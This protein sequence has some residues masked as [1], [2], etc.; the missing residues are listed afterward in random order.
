MQAS[1]RLLKTTVFI[2]NIHCAT[3]TELIATTL[4]TL[5]PRPVS[6]TAS[7]LSNRVEIYH[8]VLLKPSKIVHALHLVG[9]DIESCLSGP[10]D[11]ESRQVL[12]QKPVYFLEEFCGGILSGLQSK[13]RKRHEEI[14]GRCIS[15]KPGSS[16]SVSGSFDAAALARPGTFKSYLSGDAHDSGA[17]SGSATPALEKRDIVDLRSI[18]VGTD[19]SSSC[20]KWVATFSIQGMTCSACVNTIR[21]NLKKFPYIEKAEISA[22]S[23]SG[24]IVFSGKDNGAIIAESIEDSGYDVEIIEVVPYNAGEFQTSER[25]ITL[26]VQGIHCPNCPPRLM[27]AMETFKPAQLTVVKPMISLNDPTIVIKYTPQPDINARKVIS[28]LSAV[29]TA[30]TVKVKP[31]QSIEDRSAS[32]HKAEVRRIRRRLAISIICAIPGFII[33]IVFMSLLPKDNEYRI[34]SEKPIWKGNVS[35]AEW[36][37]LIISTPVYFFAADLFHVRAIQELRGLWSRK[38]SKPTWMKFLKFGSMNL[39]VSFYLSSVM[40]F[41]T[42]YSNSSTDVTWN[43]HCLLCIHRTS[44]YKCI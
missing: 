15:E 38:N 24:K 4:G 3:C 27:A 6:H 14:C 7:I 25:T 19:A 9:F 43:D 23:H 42:S 8:S 1:T 33:G 44:G 31:P 29:D 26:E 18:A 30:F 16:G 28:K 11:E 20:D 36:S 5:T 34:W 40:N 37:L 12:L 39:L 13:K 17:P 35:V 10:N 21:Q 32:V 2:S 22:L 41:Q